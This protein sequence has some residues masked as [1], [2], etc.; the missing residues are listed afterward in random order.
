[1]RASWGREFETSHSGLGKYKN[2]QFAS[3]ATR[4][5]TEIKSDFDSASRPAG[6]I[7]MIT[8]RS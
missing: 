6:A 1:M 8:V 4:I 2:F 7:A 3:P 5:W